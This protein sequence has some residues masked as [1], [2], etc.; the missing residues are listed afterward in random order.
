MGG[1]MTL[2]NGAP[3]A[4]PGEGDGLAG[5]GTPQSGIPTQGG[6]DQPGPWPPRPNGLFPARLSASPGPLP[7]PRPTIQPSGAPAQRSPLVV[8]AGPRPGSEDDR[9][10]L[11][12]HAEPS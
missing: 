4:S 8:G 11:V 6:R 10:S 12:N 2:I 7:P 3:G 1:S 9:T 5:R